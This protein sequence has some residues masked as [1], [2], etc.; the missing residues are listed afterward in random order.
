MDK[1]QIV[2]FTRISH[3]KVSLVLFHFDGDIKHVWGLPSTYKST[4]QLP[5]CSWSEKGTSDILQCKAEPDIY[6]RK[7]FVGAKLTDDQQADIRIFRYLPYFIQSTQNHVHMIY[8][9][10]CCKKWIF[11][12][13]FQASTNKQG[14]I[15]APLSVQDKQCVELSNKMLAHQWIKIPP[16]AENEEAV[17]CSFLYWI[18]KAKN[19][20]RP[21]SREEE[22]EK[23]GF[24]LLMRWSVF[25]STLCVPSTAIQRMKEYVCKEWCKAE[26]T[27]DCKNNKNLHYTRKKMKVNDFLQLLP[28]IPL[29]NK[30]KP[31]LVINRKHLMAIRYDIEIKSLFLVE[32]LNDVDW[33][34]SNVEQ[35][36]TDKH[37]MEC[38]IDSIKLKDAIK[39]KKEDEEQRETAMRELEEAW[40]IQK[41]NIEEWKEEE[42]KLARIHGE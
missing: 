19:M 20:I 2:D 13:L 35:W 11:D 28:P 41:K 21:L 24:H 38:E 23:I 7:L 6:L 8:V 36:E 10:L 5:S 34:F 22:K 18:Q 16:I 4:I 15:I 30:L 33:M 17:H 25:C 37:R 32:T 40:S 1:K 42:I 31:L 29:R 14:K 39:Q 9:G 27:S 12:P 3:Y 26:T